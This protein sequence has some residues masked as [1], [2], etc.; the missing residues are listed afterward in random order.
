MQP[1]RSC[2]HTEGRR[3]NR[4]NLEILDHHS[5]SN[6]LLRVT[7]GSLCTYGAHSSIAP[8]KILMNGPAVSALARFHA[9]VRVG[10]EIRKATW[11]EITEWSIC[12]PNL[13]KRGS[14]G[15]HGHGNGIHISSSVELKTSLS[16]ILMMAAPYST[17]SLPTQTK[18]KTQRV[19][20]N[21]KRKIYWRCL[22]LICLLHWVTKKQQK[23]KRVQCRGGVRKFLLDLFTWI[24]VGFGFFSP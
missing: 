16:I 19:N 6:K 17:A 24:F 4:S 5:N 22:C 2:V 21:W 15:K 13:G 3:S 23:N 11:F 20:K 18:I 9:E 7:Q 14:E 12:I 10:R 1:H 8:S